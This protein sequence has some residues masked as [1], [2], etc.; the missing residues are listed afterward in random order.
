MGL[1]QLDA[2][3]ALRQATASGLGNNSSSNNS[4]SVKDGQGSKDNRSSSGRA[5]RLKQQVNAL[6]GA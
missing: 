6:K 4:S 2:D 3:D 5:N 1:E